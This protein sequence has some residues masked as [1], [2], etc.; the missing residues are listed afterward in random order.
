M[1]ELINTTIKGMTHSIKVT[2]DGPGALNVYHWVQPY[3][4]PAVIHEGHELKFTKD[5]VAKHHITVDLQANGTLVYR[6]FDKQGNL[7]VE[8]PGI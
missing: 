2:K 7:L 8:T 6:F 5:L 1:D 3:N 4:M